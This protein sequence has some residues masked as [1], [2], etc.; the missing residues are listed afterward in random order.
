M[1]SHKSLSLFSLLVCLL[2]S[3]CLA[4]PASQH[5]TWVDLNEISGQVTQTKKDIAKNQL[6]ED[7]KQGQ[8]SVDKTPKTRDLS[9]EGGEDVG[10]TYL[11]GVSGKKMLPAGEGIEGEGVMLNFDNADIYEVIQVIA[12]TLEL[13]YII[14]PQVKGTVNIKSGQK[15]PKSELF[16]VFK[17]LLNINGLDIRDEGKHYY[18]F[19]AAKPSSL[20]IFDKGQADQLKPSSKVVTQVLPVMHISSAEAQKLVEPYLSQQAVIYNL[21]DQNTLVITDF[22]GQIVDALTILARLDVSSLSSMRIKVVRVEQAPLFD[23]RDELKEVLVALKINKKDYEG[24]QLVALE[25]VNSIML[26]G[27]N[28]ELVQTAVKWVE[29]LDRAPTGGRDSIYIYNV[30]NSVA[31]ELVD[32]V[33]SLITDKNPS[34]KSKSSGTKRNTNPTTPGSIR[35][36]GTMGDNQPQ[37]TTSPTKTV[38][39]TPTGETLASMQFAGEPSMIADDARNI[40]LI[41]ALYADYQRVVKLLERLDNM[42]T[43]VLIEVLVAEVELTDELQYGVEW[44]FK[45]NGKIHGVEAN[46]STKNGLQGA[47]TFETAADIFNLLN[48]LSTKNDL[49]VISSPQV[50]VLNNEAAT[51]NVGQQVPVVTSQI[52]DI[53][54]GI[55]TPANPISTAS[56]Q[57][58]QYKDT[59][60]I[61]NVTP[62]INAEGIILLEIDQQ[63]SSVSEKLSAGINS[64]TINTKQVKTKLAVKDGQSIL[65]GGLISKNDSDN[66]SGVPVLKDIPGLGWLFKTKNTKTSKHELLLMVTPYVIESEDVLDQYIKGFKEKV[67][68]LRRDL[69]Q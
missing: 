57:T 30:R 69:V 6:E 51:V 25:R 55:T 18:I 32:L 16:V 59:G 60:V 67:D 31:S 19:V 12:E 48:L 3:G 4:K 53:N 38:T 36:P 66:N 7:Q 33:G 64:P 35:P 37:Q 5:K 58:V 56:N 54:N 39:N 40:V 65:M 24:V 62:R 26:I 47:L 13:S 50:L 42:P 52:S 29:E 8:M 43:Q 63:V 1:I 20:A 46:L 34:S 11:K 10:N 49:T 21:A 44:A 15:I 68:G 45:N 2:L 22:E 41:R 9:A 23:L 27:Y 17:K 28:E 14:D 61:L